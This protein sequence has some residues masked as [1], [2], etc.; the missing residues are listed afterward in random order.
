MGCISDTQAMIERCRFVLH[1][2]INFYYFVFKN[3]IKNNFYMENVNLL[4]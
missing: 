2:H 3:I 4:I 1:I